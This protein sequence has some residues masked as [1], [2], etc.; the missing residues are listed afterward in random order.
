M[1]PVDFDYQMMGRLLL[2]ALFGALIGLE[3]EI[4]GRPAGFRTHLLVSL[5]SALFVAVSISFYRMFGNFGGVL[6]VG[7][8]AGRVAAQVVTGI[9]FL[10]AGAIIRERTSV[11]GLTT[12]ACLWVAAAVGVACGVGL[13]ALSALVTA[14]ALVSLIA[15]KK[16]EGMLSRDTYAIL[17]VHSDDCDGQLERITLAVQACG[18]KMTLLGMER[19]PIAGLLV[20]EFQLKLHGQKLAV[21]ALESVS[22][23]SGIRDVAVKVNAVA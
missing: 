12:A 5:G 2:A 18:Y 17:T 21:D 3:R 14:I 19:R 20:Y 15:L 10:G 4:H 11:R 22:A 23:I 16:I 1:T 13:F 7:I 9:G 8:D 6:P